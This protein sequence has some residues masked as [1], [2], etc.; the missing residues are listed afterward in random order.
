MPRFI[1][2]SLLFAWL[3]CLVPSPDTE[4]PLEIHLKTRTYDPLS[5]EVGAKSSP[6]R[7][8]D[9]DGRRRV[10]AQ[11]TRLLNPE[12]IDLLANQGARILGFIPDQA[13]VI[14]TPAGFAWDPFPLR[15]QAPIA[16]SDKWSPLLTSSLA[17]S[18]A[19][20]DPDSVFYLVLFHEDVAPEDARTLALTQGLEVRE[21]PNLLPLH[22]LVQGPEAVIRGLTAFDEVAYILPASED[23]AKGWPVVP[24]ENGIVGGYPLSPLAAAAATGPGWGS[25]RTP[26]TL[27]TTWGPLSNKLDA[28][29]TRAEIE[30]A[31]AEW[32]RVVQV[33]FRP[34][35]SSTATR[36]FNILFATRAHGD[37]FPFTG[38]T[39]VI[40]HAFY[41]SP[42]NPEPIAG[43]VHFNDDMPL[44]IGADIDLFSVA[45]HEVGHALGLPHMD[46]G[47]AVMY[48]YYRRHTALASADI[49]AIRQLY[50]SADS[51]GGGPVPTFR[52][53]ATPVANTSADTADLAGTVEN[54]TLPIRLQW[55][56]NRG[57]GGTVL[58]DSA[59]RWSVRNVPLVAGVNA[60][61]LT[62]TDASAT[63]AVESIAITR[64]ATP[65]NTPTPSAPAAPQLRVTVPNANDRTTA[66]TVR[67]TGT[68]TAAGGVRRILWNTATASGQAEGTISWAISALPLAR[69]ANAVTLRLETSDGLTATTQLTLHRDAT[70]DTTP[71]LITIVSPATVSISTSNASIVVSGTAYDSGGVAE[72]TWQNS[73]GG[74]GI[75]IGTNSWRA[76][77]PV[78]Q[79][80]NTLIIRARDASGK[81]AW[82]SINVTRR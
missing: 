48:P 72:V 41:P 80:F 81:T 12:E 46:S 9:S 19:A 70:N 16:P 75:A 67:V 61:A 33:T 1:T 29:A 63:R 21:H 37:P 22:M 78:Y 11:F 45:L 71:P 38:T 2:G 79:G 36:N 8:A 69:G 39:G 62:A 10:L 68:A 42:P 31:L 44:R 50:L 51:T 32:S 27:T 52:V 43:D 58:A 35:S 77:V 64:A 23:L 18:D 74:A 6:L 15:S 57:G 14:S 76:E 24:C 82:R 26:I 65:G 49:A 55:A 47:N 4:V 25:P 13:Y 28:T 53:T 34:G 56:N 17:L 3:L 40:A 59:R 54:G 7:A 66:P 20:R 30:R 73:A 5:T 60:I